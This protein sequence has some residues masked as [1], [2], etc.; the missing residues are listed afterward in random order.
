MQL[1]GEL[2]EGTPSLLVSAHTMHPVIMTLLWS[3][4][5]ITLNSGDKFV[6]LQL[7]LPPQKIV[8]LR[9]QTCQLT[10]RNTYAVHARIANDCASSG[11]PH[12]ALHSLVYVV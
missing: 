6:V 11:S 3:S 5:L 2:S 9:S 10:K 1:T 8:A 12:N 7:W 4:A